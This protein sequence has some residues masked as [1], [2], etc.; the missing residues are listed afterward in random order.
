MYS[1]NQQL[2][3]LVLLC[4][5]HLMKKLA[6]IGSTGSIGRQTLEV[7][8]AFPEEFTVTAMTAM[9][10]AELLEEQAKEF[11][12]KNQLGLDNLDSLLADS[13][14]VIN[15]VPGFDGLTVSLAAIRAGKTLLSANKES[16][17]IA[18]NWLRQLAQETGAEIRPLD[19]EA[20][21]IWQ[22]MYE[23]GEDKIKSVT[24]TCSGGPFFG[25]TAEELKDV[26]VE[27]ALNHPTWKMGPKVSL[28][29]ATL[30]NKIL[31][32][33]ETHN[34]FDVP[35]TD[36]HITIH[37]QSHC[38]SMVHTTTG[39]TRMHI[40]QNDMRLFISYALH[41]PN[42][43][44]CPWPLQRHKKSELHFE[45]PDP[46][47][48]R[49]LEWLRMHRGNPN[50]PVIL[51]AMNDEATRRFLAG[52]L[53]FLGIYDF[54]EE[55]LERFL[56]EVPPASLEEMIQFHDNIRDFARSRQLQP[57]GC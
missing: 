13:E 10:N 22:L 50:F 35:L 45:E 36:I 44:K 51:N 27:Q 33:Y 23:H 17:A 21:A 26:S 25:K 28:D 42:Q 48:F 8:R 1:F 2:V 37:R 53:S 16:L 54:I 3:K 19:S 40:T 31:E 38:H 18:G 9:K 11:G 6:I 29:S 7:L 49:S 14:I 56:Y 5:N 55:G 20:S 15:A 46:Q 32:V 41:Y 12:G 34:L 57:S 4:S 39:A 52:E 47:T 24:L 43:P 30:I